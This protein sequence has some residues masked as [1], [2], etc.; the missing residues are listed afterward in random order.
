MIRSAWVMVW[1]FLATLWHASGALVASVRGSPRAPERC[2]AHNRAWGRTILRAAGVTVEVEGAEYLP[3]DRA[4]VI[5]AN[6]E[7]WLDVWALSAELPVDYRFVAK[8]ELA[9]IPIFGRAWRTCGHVSVDR[10]DRASAIQ[11]LE[12]AMH[13]LRDETLSIILFPEGTRSADG[14]LLPFKKGAFVIALQAGVPIVPVAVLGGH[15]LMPKGSFRVRPG[16]MRI[17][18]GAPIPVDGMAFEDR[19]ELKD[20]ARVA[21]Q[22]LKDGEALDAVDPG[23]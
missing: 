17:R 7:S 6:H 10:S 9:G 11:S 3:R 8:K 13:R 4:Q 21:V 22:A 19:D 2:N 23:R 14:R 18:I 5:V 12:A 20:R 16:R 15:E 1:A